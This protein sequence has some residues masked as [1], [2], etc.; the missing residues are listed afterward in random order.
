MAVPKVITCLA[1]LSAAV[2]LFTSGMLLSARIS[3]NDPRSEGPVIISPRAPTA[4][5][6]SEARPS[7]NGV[8][9]SS[10]LDLQRALLKSTD[11]TGTVEIA[12]SLAKLEERLARAEEDKRRAEAKVEQMASRGRRTRR[13]PPS[14]VP[15]TDINDDDGTLNGDD[16]EDGQPKMRPRRSV[17]VEKDV[18]EP[19][20]PQPLPGTNVQAQMHLVEMLNSQMEEEKKQQ[21]QRSLLESL[22]APIAAVEAKMVDAITQQS[23]ATERSQAQLAAMSQQ[24]TGLLTAL[25]AHDA[26]RALDVPSSRT[27]TTRGPILEEKRS[28]ERQQ[29]SAHERAQAEELRQLKALVTSESARSQA[30]IKSLNATLMKK[31][32][33]LKEMSEGLKRAT[34]QAQNRFSHIFNQ[35]VPHGTVKRDSREVPRT[36]LKGHGCRTPPCSRDLVTCKMNGNCCIDLMF[37]MLVDFSAFLKSVN[38]TH[39]LIAGSLLGAIRD[40]DIIPHTSDLDIVIPKSEWEKAA[41]I[42]EQAD[43]PRSYYFQVDPYERSCARLCAVWQGLPVNSKDY[44]KNFDWDTDQ[45]GADLPYYMD[46]YD[47]EMDFVK[48]FSHLF[49]P[50]S[51]ANIRNVSF[52]APRDSRLWVEAKYGTGWDTPDYHSH[53]VAKIYPTLQEGKGWS[54]GQM[55]LNKAKSNGNLAKTVL[56]KA[57]VD[58]KTGDIFLPRSIALDFLNKERTLEFV[59][60]EDATLD[61]DVLSGTVIL[62]KVDE[63][64]KGVTSFSLYFAREEERETTIRGLTQRSTYWQRLGGPFLEVDRCA[65]GSGGRVLTECDPTVM[66]IDLPSHLKVPPNAELLLVTCITDFGESRGSTV[67]DLPEKAASSREDLFWNGLARTPAPGTPD[68]SLTAT[69]MVIRMQ[70]DHSQCISAVSPQSG[71]DVA[72][73]PCGKKWDAFILANGTFHLHADPELCITVVNEKGRSRIALGNCAGALQFDVDRGVALRQRSPTS[74]TCLAVNRWMSTLQLIPCNGDDSQQAFRFDSEPSFRDQTDA[75]NPDDA[76]ALD[77]HDPRRPRLPRQSANAAMQGG[78]AYQARRVNDEEL[79]DTDNEG[80]EDSEEKNEQQEDDAEEENDAER[81]TTEMLKLEDTVDT[82]EKVTGSGKSQFVAKI[83]TGF[84]NGFAGDY[85]P[86]LLTKCDWSE[87]EID[88]VRL[89]SYV[90]QMLLK[91]PQE[92]KVAWRLLGE[93]IE[94]LGVVLERCTLPEGTVIHSVFRESLRHFVAPDSFEYVP[95]EKV[96]FDDHNMYH[97]VNEALRGYLEGDVTQ[98][99]RKFGEMAVTFIP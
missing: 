59:S 93:W 49:Y 33:E 85:S 81:K 78:H 62:G 10:A 21:Q 12:R 60:L 66:Y 87:L 73:L 83:T 16:T 30:A 1:G 77:S 95:G 90:Q 79:D 58:R 25:M 36:N 46:I 37:D 5:L 23:Y 40:N 42:N 44:T 4:D 91:D 64:D 54:A 75:D 28:V 70:Q 8:S 52:P 34:S 94:P 47:L 3:A 69:A 63:D 15:E 7:T 29:E 67:T 89:A 80:Q 41:M 39:F 19:S 22:Q 17:V 13:K 32:A 84:L 20:T 24:M 61:E 50:L 53:G 71:G 74:I 86:V 9:E 96:V 11:S 82:A 26:P 56:A 72:V 45:L 98:F 48:A 27:T 88:E 2:F 31:E 57:L 35:M 14:Y 43:Q 55:F 51:Q 97:E 6:R 65:R 76:E 92:M 99:A 68:S 18:Q 38:V